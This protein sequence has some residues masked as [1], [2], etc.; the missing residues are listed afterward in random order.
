MLWSLMSRFSKLASIHILCLK[1]M[2]SDIKSALNDQYEFM[3]LTKL[4][5]R[6]V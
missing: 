4:L 2:H 6:D 3:K 1:H 5:V